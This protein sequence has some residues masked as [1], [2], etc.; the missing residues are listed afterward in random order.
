MNP[1]AWQQR[2]SEGRIGF[3]LGR[4]H[5]ALVRE[6]ARFESARSVL[7]PLAGKAH[8]LDLLATGGRRV[9]AN[10]IV[11]QAVRTFFEERA[12]V[13]TESRPH[14]RLRLAHASIE[15]D[16]GDFFTLRPEHLGGPVDAAFDRAAL[17]AVDPGERSR[18]A[19][20]L[21]E[22]LRPGAIVLLVVFDMGRPPDVGPPF[23]FRPGE[24]EALFA[25]AFSVQEL[26]PITAPD[27]AH[28]RVYELRRHE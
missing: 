16:V 12:L 7:V 9:I 19:A 1:D 3:H 13:P 25:P 24:V 2:W 14:G 27:G 8:D 17:V 26:E 28:E 22:L 4:P 6:L 21:A 18:Y 15:L 23:S 20:V 5:P 11:E 10:E